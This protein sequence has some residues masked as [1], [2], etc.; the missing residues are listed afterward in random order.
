MSV[1]V[2]C[3]VI[4]TLSFFDTWTFAVTFELSRA[5]ADRQLLGRA[6]DSLAS[7]RL[8]LAFSRLGKMADE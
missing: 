2:V 4:K 8:R 6:A 3:I 1:S 5:S 7:P